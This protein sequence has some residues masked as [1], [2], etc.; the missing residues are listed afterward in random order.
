MHAEGQGWIQSHPVFFWLLVAYVIV[1]GLM[2]FADI[3]RPIVRWYQS[4]TWFVSGTGVI[5]ILLKQIGYRFSVELLAFGIA[6]VVGALGGN[7]YVIQRARKARN[8]EQ[9]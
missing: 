3:R 4:Q 5:D 6:C 9:L 8:V 2:L 1:S 7:I